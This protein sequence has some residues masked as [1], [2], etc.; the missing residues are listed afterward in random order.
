MH[1]SGVV[2]GGEQDTTSGLPDPDNMAGSRSAENTILADQ[3]L[4][5]AIGSTD[6]CDL[7]GDLGVPVTAIS[8]N[9]EE[10]TLRALRDRLEDADDE[11]LGVVLLLENLDLLAKTR[12]GARKLD[13]RRTDMVLL[14]AMAEA[15][16]Q[17]ESC[18]GKQV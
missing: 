8:S 7:L 18:H 5:H 15:S 9:D 6:L 17:V 14:L 11:G 16:I 13:V 10:G 1:T 12:A 4:L 3:Q 2:T